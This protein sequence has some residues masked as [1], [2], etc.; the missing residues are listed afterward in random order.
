M[1]IAISRYRVGTAQEVPCLPSGDRQ[2]GIR[3]CEMR[4]A[5][6][7]LFKIKNMEVIVFVIKFIGKKPNF[8]AY[9]FSVVTESQFCDLLLNVRPRPVSSICLF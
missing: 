5:P 8:A 7:F 9:I 1:N 2:I 6:F 4:P 3:I